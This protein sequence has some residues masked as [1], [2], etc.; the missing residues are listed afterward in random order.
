MKKRLAIL[1]LSAVIVLCTAACQKV[2]NNPPDSSDGKQ[3]SGTPAES[4]DASNIL[5]SFGSRSYN[6]KDFRIFCAN[7]FND[8][9]FVRQAPTEDADPADRINSAL[10][11]RDSMLE[12]TYNIKITYDIQVN[13][14]EVA[15]I[16]KELASTNEYAMDLLLGSLFYCGSNMLSEG[17]LLDINTISGIKLSNNWWNQ[18]MTDSFTLN[19]KTFF[20]TG[21]ITTRGPTSVSLVLFNKNLFDTY[22][23]DYPYQEVYDGNW[24]FEKMYQIYNGKSADLDY[25]GEI[26]L[27]ND[28]IGFLVGS[29]ASYFGCGGRYTEQESDGSYTGV[30]NS[31]AN[32]EILQKL[33]E[34]FNDDCLHHTY[35]PGVSAFSSDRALLIE[36]AGCDLSLFRDMEGEFGALPFP[37]YNEE[38]KEYINFA[39]P[40][41]TTCAA[42]PITLKDTEFS[43]FITEAMAALSKYTSS[44]EQYEVLMKNKELRDDDSKKMLEICVSGSTYDI[45]FN[46]NFGDVRT[47][48][49][50]IL[51]K[52][53]NIASKFASIGDKFNDDLQSLL[54]SVS[55]KN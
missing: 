4:Y 6:G 32:I 15:R 40:W 14:N 5:D 51:T 17:L 25:D 9:V 11:K 54:T 26:T 7:A 28:Q 44:P 48:I 18:N 31:F 35:Y 33:Q 30:Y 47:I 42:F 52:D 45:G 2:S 23:I 39:N 3:S 22:Q 36:V 53:N 50:G 16:A 43:G 20:A 46:Y 24:T 19:G 12:E 27:E 38:Q 8:S 10:Y 37:K 21:D 1:F 41:I 34:W 13:D 29:Y 55:E 49:D